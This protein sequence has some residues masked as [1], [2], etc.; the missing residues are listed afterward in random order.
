MKQICN[1]VKIKNSITATLGESQRR[2][3]VGAA[4]HNCKKLRILTKKLIKML[5]ILI[6]P[7][8]DALGPSFFHTPVFA[9]DGF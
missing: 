6:V 1:L 2:V 4:A 5:R 9:G 7:A 8:R 3:S